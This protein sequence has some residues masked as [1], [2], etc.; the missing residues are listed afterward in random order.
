MVGMETWVRC[1]FEHIQVQR[2]S[3]RYTVFRGTS[4]Q[5]NDLFSGEYTSDSMMQVCHT[6]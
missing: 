6:E 5:M 4:Y 3:S 1:N 2:F